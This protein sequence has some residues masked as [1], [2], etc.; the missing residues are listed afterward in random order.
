MK[1]GDEKTV[2]GDLPGQ[3]RAPRHLAGKEASFAVT[4]KD[5]QGACRG[6]RST[7]TTRQAVRHGIARR[8]EGLPVT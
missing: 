1:A 2:D 3:L 8:D 6:Q 5:V 7:T 4:V